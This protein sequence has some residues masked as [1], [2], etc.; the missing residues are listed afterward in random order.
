MKTQVRNFALG[1]IFAALLSSP[2]LNAQE[3]AVA[4]IPFDFHVLNMTLPAGA[5][6]VVR[7][8]STHVLRVEN[9]GGRDGI[10]LLAETND[11][12]GGDVD[13]KL[14]F[15]CYDNRCFLSQINMPDGRT[16]NLSKGKLEKEI[17]S[18]GEKVAMAYVAFGTR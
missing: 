3:R 11:L 10:F 15:H 6:T 9:N 14:T 12:K 5:Y 2:L 4:E 16:Y 17:A 1:G 7:A 18:G 8:A 13:P